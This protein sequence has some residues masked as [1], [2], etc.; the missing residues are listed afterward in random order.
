[1]LSS[2][3]EDATSAVD[4]VSGGVSS[5]G[6][7]LASAG[8]GSGSGSDDEGQQLRAGASWEQALTPDE[9][10]AMEHGV[11]PSGLLLPS[12]L[13]QL[14]L[15]GASAQGQQQGQQ[16]RPVSP[17]GEDSLPA[18]EKLALLKADFSGIASEEVSAA[19]A[20]CDGSLFAAADLLRAFAEEDSSAAAKNGSGLN[21]GAHTGARA[22]AAARADGGPC[23]RPG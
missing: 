2:C 19:L 10:A 7:E 6:W 22:A 21:G 15:Q 17:E 11:F 16:Q 20:A 14:R 9:L 8:S 12:Q 1:M 23:P 3:V 18:E 13:E 4:D 5:A